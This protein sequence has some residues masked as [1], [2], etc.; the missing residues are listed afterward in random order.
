MIAHEGLDTFRME[1]C[2][3][4]VDLRQINFVISEW[5]AGSK[6]IPHPANPARNV[7]PVVAMYY[8]SSCL[9]QPPSGPVTWSRNWESSTGLDITELAFTDEQRQIMSNKRTAATANTP[10]GDERPT[11]RR[12]G[13]NQQT[14][15]TGPAN[16][17]PTTS[18]PVPVAQPATA[19]THMAVAVA[20]PTP[21]PA[22]PVVAA[23]TPVATPATNG[24]TNAANNVAA[25]ATV[26]AAAPPTMPPFAP[27]GYNVPTAPFPS[28]ASPFPAY[29]TPQPTMPN[30]FT[31]FTYGG[32]PGPY[33][34]PGYPATQPAPFP[35]FMPQP[36]AVGH[37][38]PA[39]QA[40]TSQIAPGQAPQAN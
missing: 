10:T 25:A 30:G 37:F 16:A 34:M 6:S 11:T 1:G 9:E 18:P 33:Q 39:G 38:N 8:W 5:A 26:A 24:A 13:N 17:P 3:K 27:P 40:P 4:T 22:L 36:A 12:K 31:G 23:P 20:G 14:T 32:F 15:T 2:D 7:L 28:M 21:T 19:N 29:F 35:G